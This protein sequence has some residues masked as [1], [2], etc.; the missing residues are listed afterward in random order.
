MTTYT[1]FA[2]AL[3]EMRTIGGVMSYHGT[4]SDGP[5]CWEIDD[6]GELSKR[7]TVHPLI[8]TVA[9]LRAGGLSDTEIAKELEDWG[10]SDEGL[11]VSIVPVNG[12]FGLVCR[13]GDGAPWDCGGGKT[14][15]LDELVEYIAEEL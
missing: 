1:N 9:A 5:E 3:T 7:L 10:L 11:R 15:S 6:D 12:E 4:S 13:R 14:G 8:A 2:A